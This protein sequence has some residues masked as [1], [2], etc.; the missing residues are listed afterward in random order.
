MPDTSRVLMVM[1]IGAGVT[2]GLRTVPFA[3][4]ARLRRWSA[5]RHL[6]AAMP[7][8]ILTI[9][10]V[11]FL[12]DLDLAEPDRGGPQVI[13]VLIAVGLLKWRGSASLAIVASTASYMAL[14]NLVPGLR[15]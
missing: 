13:G 6:S 1:L 5:V 12:R 7:A 8:G 4:L 14:V 10:A 15:T 11:Y 3:V 2:L 9:L